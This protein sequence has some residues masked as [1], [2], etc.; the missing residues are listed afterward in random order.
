MPTRWGMPPE[1][2]L[3]WLDEHLSISASQMQQWALTGATH[4]LQRL[5]S[6]GGTAFFG[7]VGTVL[8]FTVMLFLLFFVLRDGRSMAMTAVGLRPGCDAVES[9][10]A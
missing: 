1:K 5:A 9:A 4:L 3:A 6:F 8:S 2:A 10:S 7:A